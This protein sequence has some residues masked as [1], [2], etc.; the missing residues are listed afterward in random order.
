MIIVVYGSADGPIPHLR[1]HQY[2]RWWEAAGHEVRHVAALPLTP[3]GLGLDASAFDGADVVIL[4]RFY[5]VDR[6]DRPIGEQD[7]ISDSV[8]PWLASRTDI[9][10]LWDVDDDLIR[11]S[12]VTGYEALYRAQRRQVEALARMADVVTVATPYLAGLY[13]PWAAERPWVLRNAV[14]P[15]AYRPVASIY[16]PNSPET[17][18]DG[19]EYHP[20]AQQAATGPRNRPEATTRIVAYG[21]GARMLDLWADRGYPVGALERARASGLVHTAFLGSTDVMPGLFDEAVGHVADPAA[22]PQ[23]LAGQRPDVVMAPL[24]DS[25]FAHGKSELHWLEATACGA[26]LIASDLRPGPYE[27]ARGAAVL[28]RTRS[29]WEEGLMRLVQDGSYRHQLVAESLDR[30]AQRYTLQGRAAEWLE[31]IRWTADHRGQRQSKEYQ[32]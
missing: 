2:H 14:D 11:T 24:A 7:W 18:R 32:A 12:P 29:E 4:R 10:I 13:G 25:L 27:P 9:G 19:T 23:A 1:C 22:W 20:V 8:L 21:M 26:A 15:C 30:V 16:P 17:G 3:D 6:A 28:C 5:L 31:A